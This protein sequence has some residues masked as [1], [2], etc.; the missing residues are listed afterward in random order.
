MLV[1][2][3]TVRFDVALRRSEI[4]LFR[5]ALLSRLGGD[6]PYLHN[7]SASGVVYRYPKVQYRVQGGKGCVVCMNEGMEAM[8]ALLGGD[9]L[10][11]E[12][13]VGSRS[14]RVGVESVRVQEFR[15]GMGAEPVRYGLRDWLALNQTNYARWRGLDESGRVSLLESVLSGN[16]LSMGKGFW[17][18]VPGPLGV[19]L[20]S[21]CGGERSRWV[22]YKGQRLL[23]MDVEFESYGWLP[24]GM[25]LGKGVS[26]G[27]G[28]LYRP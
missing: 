9:L 10:S 23:S 21:G 24:Y 4:P 20:L 11:G 18:D 5:G 19:R 22:G 2:M 1:R 14:V 26:L 6:N 15:L 8:E 25:G 12:V 3:M 17:W 27:H 16:I 7:H 28:V 13:R